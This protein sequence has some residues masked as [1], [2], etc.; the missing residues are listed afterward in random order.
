MLTGCRRNETPTLRWTHV[1]LDAGELPLSD[2]KTGARM[3]PLS[4][5][6][7]G[8]LAALPRQTGNP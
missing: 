5:A 6:A 4:R 8:V 3:V 1:D 2:T 7:V